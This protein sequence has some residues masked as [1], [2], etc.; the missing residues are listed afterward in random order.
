[1]APARTG[2][3]SA[4]AGSI[5]LVVHDFI[6]RSPDELSLAKGD[7]IELIE[8]DDDF[9]DGWFLGKHLNNGLTGL[10]PEVYTT[11]APRGTLASS[12]NATRIQSDGGPR[13][14]AQVT[15]VGSTP[16]WGPSSTNTYSMPPT[17]NTT[18]ASSTPSQT[19]L[20]SSLPSP[21]VAGN[22]NFT[23]ATDSPVMS[24]TLS[25][26]DEHITDMHAPRNSHY[27][28]KQALR[29][30]FIAGHETDEEEHQTYTEEE[31]MGWT[32]KRV[33]EY[34]EDHGVEKPHCDVFQEQE[35]SGEVLLAMDQNSLFIK[36][37]E[38]GSVG[39]RLKTWHKVKALQDEVRQSHNLIATR[40]VS[41]YSAGF[42]PDELPT[43]GGADMGRK[44]TSTLGTT[45]SPR[46]W[47]P[48]GHSR[49]SS[50]SGA[51]VQ[52]STSYSGAPIAKAQEDTIS[53]LQSM[54]SMARAE[55]TYRPSAQGVRNLQH[56]RR[57]SS[58]DSTTSDG[59]TR[60]SHRKQPSLEKAWLPGQPGY[61]NGRH[62]HS[63]STEFEAPK[64]LSSSLAPG[65]P[66]NVDRGYFSSNETDSRHRRNVLTKRHS[67]SIT[68]VLSNDGSDGPF[69]HIR[70]LSGTSSHFSRASGAS[71]PTTPGGTPL[72][73]KEGFKRV[74]EM[75]FGGYRGSPSIA[76][77]ESNLDKPR[78]NAQ[79]MISPIVTK[80]EP[81]PRFSPN[82]MTTSPG[83]IL[84]TGS[85]AS[86][87]KAGPSPSGLNM[88]MF[89]AAR[90][91][92]PGF[93]SISDAV[94]KEEKSSKPVTSPTR[95]GSSSPSTEYQS[96]DYSKSD[97]TSRTSAGSANNLMPP[98]PS[99]KR[100][101]A[102]T[103][104]L[105]SA[106]TRGLE[107][108]P[109]AEQMTT[110]DYSGWMK[111]K[112][113]SLM[114]TWKP[115]LFILRGRRLS[116]YYSDDDT[117]EKGLIDISFHRVLP[118]H[119]EALTGLHATVTGAAGNTGSPLSGST[120]TIAEQDLRNHPA[121][122]GEEGNEGLFIFKLVPPKAGLAKGVNFTKPTVHYFAVNS[123]QEGRLWMAALMK[124]TID[125]DDTN[126]VTT[127]YNQK[128]I[129]LAKARARRERPPALKELDGDAEDD[130]INDAGLGIDGLRN[131]AAVAGAENDDLATPVDSLSI[132]PLSSIATSMNDSDTDGLTQAERESFAALT[133]P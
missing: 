17:A 40:S 55:N 47:V 66:E 34:L 107:K 7:R 101:R 94:T 60:T 92:I 89:S 49:E 120:P 125:R 74:M 112:S 73:A 78:T 80:L 23:I 15:V 37:F 13:R 46:A 123:R 79:P 115:R 5:L 82:A 64:E 59:A 42:D 98:P 9:G 122:Q 19:A 133:T 27:S 61:K 86:S 1:M 29:Q 97:H 69:K 10:F 14:A 33:A 118:A 36:E 91:K 8:R 105:T 108:K 24:E 67:A 39:R 18:S 26:I 62:L 50:R 68:P 90:A 127:T 53:P 126:V 11:P 2:A 41:E 102:R 65:S 99:T 114:S 3:S 32:P 21:A 71:E 128:T 96:V 93:R 77:N 43:A 85:D 12:T 22:R 48:P 72:S 31:V 56:S 113:G 88:S 119:N 63:I 95:T 45:S 44:R 121:K 106:Y 57:H 111:K 129:S 83:R 6:A 16:S 130:S 104:K 117:E 81:G 30:S 124:A 52:A 58:I 110:C 75:S 38:L 132:P 131:P 100:P 87:D 103:K 70:K 35:I 116:Y 25:V 84:E 20:R 76:L 4:L 51:F 28:N 54:T 109:P